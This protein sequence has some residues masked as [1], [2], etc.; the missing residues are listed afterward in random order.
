MKHNKL[1]KG[2]TATALALTVPMSM[3]AVGG[4][5]VSAAESDETEIVAGTKIYFDVE[6]AGWKNYKDI[7]CHIWRADGTGVWPSWQTRKELCVNEDN[8]LYSYDVTKTGNADEIVASGSHNYY[9]V[10]FS[11]DTGAQTYHVIMNGDCLG[12]T[13]YVTGNSFENPIDSNKTCV[14][15]AWRNHPECGA[16]KNI[17]ST[18]KVIGTAFAEGATDTTLL[19]DFLLTYITDYGIADTEK[20]DHTA[21]LANELGVSYRDVLECVQEKLAASV[22]SGDRTQESA[23][24]VE[25]TVIEVLEKASIKNPET[26][27][28]DI[29]GDEKVDVLD[30][31]ALQF[32]ISGQNVYVIYDNADV[33]KDGKFDVQDVT[34]LQMYIASNGESGGSASTGSSSTGSSSTGSSSTAAA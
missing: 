17:T 32:F 1:F 28:Y 25:R 24:L 8:G 15:A 16:Q 2:I 23:D 31:T 21:E 27:S 4:L 20:T 13:C 11:A 18:G 34:A 10:I 19:A 12:D 9:C 14:E 22:E 5:S 33:N 6:S 3:L 26:D 7:Y 29:N 30:V